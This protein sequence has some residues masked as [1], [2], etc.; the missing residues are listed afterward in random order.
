MNRFALSPTMIR[1]P[2]CRIAPCS[3][4]YLNQVL[5]DARRHDKEFALLFLDID[6]F[7]RV[8]DTLGHQA[9]D[10]LL[11]EVTERLSKCLRQ[12][13][14]VARIE[15]AGAPDEILARLGGDEFVIL[16]P[17]ISGSHAPSK[18]ADRLLKIHGRTL[19]RGKS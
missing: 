7:K 18:L 13:D 11:Q 19:Q 10:A 17:D 3:G 14:Y 16:I 1:S 5:A 12:A 4:N 9:G 6:D 15:N 2:V 8:N